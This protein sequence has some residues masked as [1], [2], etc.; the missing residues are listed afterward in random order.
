[1]ADEKAVD[2][3]GGGNHLQQ[4]AAGG[5][6]GSYAERL[7][8]NVKFDQ[9][10]KRNVLEITLEKTNREADFVIGPDSVERL[11]QSIG[12]DVEHQVEG[13]QVKFNYGVNMIKVWV[14]Q[15]V[16]LE[17]FCKN[18]I[19]NMGK[20]LVTGVIRPAGR[21]DV[22]VTFSGLDFNT[23]DTLIFEYLRKFGGTLVNGNVI[24]AG[25]CRHWQALSD[26]SRQ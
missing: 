11:C 10:L 7:K 20:G 2:T 12:M 15:G 9:R 18:E 4:G 5:Q 23:P 17:R 19:I 1:M 21:K 8:T 26:I 25:I 24:L 22:T 3:G 6:Q 14:Q 16:N 13:Y